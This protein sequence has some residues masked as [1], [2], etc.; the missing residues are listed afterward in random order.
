MDAIT[1][2]FGDVVLWSVWF[3]IWTAVLV[4]W[5]RCLFDVFTDGTLSGWGKAGWVAVLIFVPLVGAL[6]Y[7][8]VRGAR[9]PERQPAAGEYQHTVSAT[10][11]PAAQIA[12]AK[13]LLD[14]G[15]IDQAEY[16][17]LKAK[18]L[19]QST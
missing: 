4:V 9:T 6:I 13:S 17:A 19:A 15:A 7:L 1:T 12:S 11:D 18:A 16:D 8:V 14:F 2:D 10:I 5:A 3:F